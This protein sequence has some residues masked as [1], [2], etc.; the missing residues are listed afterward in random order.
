MC[1]ESI[2][3]GKADFYRVQ[4]DRLRLVAMKKSVRDDDHWIKNE[5]GRLSV[6][7]YSFSAEKRPNWGLIQSMDTQERRSGLRR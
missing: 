7:C 6:F 3:R 2:L 4:K 1:W 5:R